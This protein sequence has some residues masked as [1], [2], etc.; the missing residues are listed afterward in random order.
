MKT[1]REKAIGKLDAE[2]QLLEWGKSGTVT[3]SCT[4]AEK[5]FYERAVSKSWRLQRNGWPDFLV[6]D[7]DRIFAVEVKTFSDIIRPAQRETFRMLE[8]AGIR[9]FVWT[10]SLPNTLIPWQKRAAKQEENV[11]RKIQRLTQV[12]DVV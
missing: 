5:A 6:D 3:F 8:R 11:R 10:P 7:G 9:V 1:L 12:A 4:R 2:L